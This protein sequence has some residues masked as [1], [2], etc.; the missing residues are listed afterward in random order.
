ME[1]RRFTEKGIEEFRKYLSNLRSGATATPPHE[2]LTD[3]NGSEP[4]PG[5][6]EVYLG[7]KSTALRRMSAFGVGCVCFI[8]TRFAHLGRMDRGNRVVTTAIS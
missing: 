5:S 6:A 1:V 8:L 3:P 4:V 2:L 7:L